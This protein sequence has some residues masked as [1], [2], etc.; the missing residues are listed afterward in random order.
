M[1]PEGGYQSQS[2]PRLG[3]TKA[4]DYTDPNI[5]NEQGLH[6]RKRCQGAGLVGRIQGKESMELKENQAY[7]N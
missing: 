3:N 1:K 6:G 4:E 7:R 5:K 2:E